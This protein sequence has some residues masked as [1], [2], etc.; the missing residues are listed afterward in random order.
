MSCGGID[1]DTNDKQRNKS[2]KQTGRKFRLVV[3]Q[4]RN[5][6]VA[7]A[8]TAEGIKL[9]ASRL[10]L[11]KSASL[12]VELVVAGSSLQVHQLLVR[13]HSE[14]FENVR[15]AFRRCLLLEKSTAPP[16]ML[17]SLFLTPPWIT[18]HFA[19][20]FLPRC[21]LSRAEARCICRSFLR[22]KLFNFGQVSGSDSTVLRAESS[23]VGRIL[24]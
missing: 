23:L 3:I 10:C 21:E 9:A 8:R 5:V 16:G 13:K 19:K 11:S 17:V 18:W 4:F 15:R 1:I 7:D 24:S 14:T 22:W 6:D 20:E 2:E 12:E